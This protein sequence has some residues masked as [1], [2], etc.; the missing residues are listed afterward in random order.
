MLP[1]HNVPLFSPPTFHLFYLLCLV[2]PG[3]DR[4]WFTIMPMHPFNDF[5]RRGPPNALHRACYAGVEKTIV[6]LSTR[7]S[8]SAMG[9]D[10]DQGDPE[11][12]TALMLS[13][14]IGS[15]RA[16]K[17]LLDNGADV[18]IVA[19]QGHTA[20]QLAAEAGAFFKRSEDH[21]G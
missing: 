5:R 4:P 14:H 9:I 3:G 11:A 1:V 12:M 10:I 21:Q 15:C 18:S 6:S 8:L 20:L 2:E 13:A 17:T 19:Y 7:D 16:V